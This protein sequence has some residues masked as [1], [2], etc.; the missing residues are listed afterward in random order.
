[1]AFQWY[2]VAGFGGGLNLST[3]P[4][5]IADQ[6]WSWCNGWIPRLGTAE[7]ARD[8][9]LPFGTGSV[10]SGYNVTCLFPIPIDVA[11]V[12][13]VH[14]GLLAVSGTGPA[15][16]IYHLDTVTTNLT[17][18][19]RLGATVGAGAQ[20]YGGSAAI[21]NNTI[22]IN[23]GLV[24][25]SNAMMRWNGSSGSQYVALPVPNV[26]ANFFRS[27]ND[28][29]FAIGVDASSTGAIAS[30][31]LAWSD[32]L[33]DSV[34]IRLN[35]NTADYVLLH[36]S[37]SGATGLEALNGNTLGIFH[38]TSIEGVAA[39]GGTPA[40]TRQLIAAGVGAYEPGST[41]VMQPLGPIPGGVLFMGPDDYYVTAGG[42]PERI[43]SKLGRYLT[44]RLTPAT[45]VTM[46]RG[47]KWWPEQGVVIVPCPNPSATT[48]E[49]M[50]FEPATGAWSR[51]V[52]T[53]TTNGAFGLLN[54]GVAPNIHVIA[55]GANLW[56]QQRT[57]GNFQVGAYVHTKDFAL[58]GP[59][60]AVYVDR[61]KVDWEAR[62]NLD[63]VLEVR[64]IMRTEM[65]S[66]VSMV[67]SPGQEADLQDSMVTLG[68][69][70]RNV[71]E[72]PC[73]LK[74][75]YLRLSF[76]QSAFGARVRGFSFRWAPANDRFNRFA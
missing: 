71:S 28:R 33:S 24:G 12:G 68:T 74:G 8:Y 13:H 1:M 36:D 38:S 75:K 64:A 62:G 3:H 49:L 20:P 6:E 32:P 46:L 27:F 65:G 11:S 43:G 48:V 52:P 17:E 69:L 34:W 61:I 60:Q 10:A 9:M 50:L 76:T 51:Q 29:L 4:A 35:D 63:A 54:H 55:N 73:R 39:T 25:G 30:R 42:S 57:G 53:I 56:V 5:A 45:S 31:I 23:G 19:T 72:L 40:F 21:F 37:F 26:G 41:G 7:T 2:T 47:V 14:L 22:V 18:I 70:T 66:G 58:G 59:G 67:G 15:V 16:K 44:T